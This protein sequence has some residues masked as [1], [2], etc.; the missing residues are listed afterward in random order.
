[1]RDYE[2]TVL[3]KADLDDETRAQLIARVEGW[4][5]LGDDE[6]D[7][8]VAHHWGKRQMAYEINKQTEAYYVFYE[9]RLDPAKVGEIERNMLYVEEIIRHLFIRKDE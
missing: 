3:F 5:T 8:P 7:K 1:M 2:V 6:A 9:A 4:L